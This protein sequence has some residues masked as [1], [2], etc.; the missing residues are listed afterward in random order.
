MDQRRGRLGL[1]LES[2]QIGPIAGQLRLENLHG[3]APLQ[4]LLFGQIDFGHRPA[5]QAPQ[6][7]KIAQ[8]P[9]GKVAVRR[10][11]R[12]IDCGGQWFGGRHDDS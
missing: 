8:L 1:D 2:L 9:A 12:Q 7:M 6:Q 11:E 5:A 4:P 10:G 3:H